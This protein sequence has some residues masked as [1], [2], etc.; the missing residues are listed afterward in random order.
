MGS[1]PLRRRTESLRS[2]ETRCRGVLTQRRDPCI[3]G[4]GRRHTLAGR[5]WRAYRSGTPKKHNLPAT[6]TEAS[7]PWNLVPARHITAPTRPL[8]L[9]SV[10]RP[11]SGNGTE[12]SHN[13]VAV[14]EIGR[15]HV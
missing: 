6:A 14:R 4:C 3:R 13:G 8:G 11:L 15:A 1:V 12:R 5:S 9:L 10:L 2:V 7:K